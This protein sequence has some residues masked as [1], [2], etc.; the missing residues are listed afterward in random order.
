MGA[1]APWICHVIFQKWLKIDG[2]MLR[3]VWQ[4]LNSLSIRVTFTAMVPGAYGYPA[5]ARSVG[6]RHPSC[7]YCKETWRVDASN[8]NLDSMF[9]MSNG[10][11]LHVWSLL[12][13]NSIAALIWAFRQASPDRLHNV[14][15]FCKCRSA[16]V[17]NFG[18]SR[19]SHLIRDNPL[20]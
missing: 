6:N 9:E 15:L 20:D 8:I 17:C 11:F 4:A 12:R 1:A 14:L 3:G 19:A 10:C 18:T 7:N 16:L 2:Y 13:N 5:D